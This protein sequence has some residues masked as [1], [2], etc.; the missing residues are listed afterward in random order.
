MATDREELIATRRSI[1]I[2]AL[3]GQSQQVIDRAT[4]DLDR[5]NFADHQD[6]IGW[7]SEL[8]GISAHSTVKEA[9]EEDIDEIMEG[10]SPWS[11]KIY[12][13]KAGEAS[14]AEIDEI[15]KHMRI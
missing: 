10:I 9:T 6:F 1:A 15:F 7:I 3:E 14:Q 8:K 12:K 13:P 4:K 11:G 2:S 5:M